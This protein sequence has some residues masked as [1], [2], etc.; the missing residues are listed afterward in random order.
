[1]TSQSAL[2]D[3]GPAPT[4]A[5]WSCPT[6][7]GTKKKLGRCK[8]CH[9][10]PPK[11]GGGAWDRWTKGILRVVRTRLAHLSEGVIA[12]TWEALLLDSRPIPEEVRALVADVA[13]LPFSAKRY[14][15][16]A[17]Q[18]LTTHFVQVTLA[19][20][21]VRGTDADPHRVN[22]IARRAAAL[23]WAQRD[24]VEAGEAFERQHDA[25]LVEQAVLEQEA[26]DLLRSEGWRNGV[27]LDR[28]IDRLVAIAMRDERGTYGRPSDE[29]PKDARIKVADFRIASAATVRVDDG[30]EEEAAETESAEAARRAR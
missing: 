8:P 28:E 23:I 2:L 14:D 27:K 3:V 7:G 30:A 20:Q 17:N 1:M 13:A 15:R 26:R 4:K 25:E 21:G 5:P 24:R 9:V 18:G 12:D 19:E 22:N 16:A 11:P 6:C 10:E 29:Y